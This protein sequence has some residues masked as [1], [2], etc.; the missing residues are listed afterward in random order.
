L[1]AWGVQTVEQMEG[2]NETTTFK[3]PLELMQQR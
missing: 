3:I 1:Q 2:V